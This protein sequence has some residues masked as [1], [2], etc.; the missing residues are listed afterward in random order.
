M[1]FWS[2]PAANLLAEIGVSP[3]GLKS[4]QAQ[5]RSFLPSRRSKPRRSGMVNWSTIP[6]EEIVPGDVVVLN[7]GDV[8]PGDCLLLESNALFADVGILVVYALAAEVAKCLFYQVHERPVVS[9]FPKTK[10]GY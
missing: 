10:T 5:T 9:R 4:V 6:V 3:Q 8:V 1:T 2:T 7:A